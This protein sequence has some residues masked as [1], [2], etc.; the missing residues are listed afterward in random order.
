MESRRA[1]RGVMAIVFAASAAMTIAWCTSMSAMGGM[2]MPGGWA[3]SMMWMW[4]PKQSWLGAA[5]SFVGMWVVMMVAMM[6]PS[7]T[8]TLWRYRESIGEAG[9]AWPGWLTSLVGAAYFAVWAV[10]AVIVF[11]LGS[12]LAD[13]AMRESALAHVVPIVVGVAVLVAGVIQHTEW[14]ARRLAYC[15]EV[16]DRHLTPPVGAGAAWREGWCLGLHCVQSCAGLT[17]AMLAVG[18]MDLRTMAAVAAAVTFERV[19]PSGMRVARI[20]GVV[21]VAVGLVVIVQAAGVQ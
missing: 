5:A 8:P 13:I 16:A 7:L 19:A 4:S 12:A 9:G 15:R 2:E 6:L 21:I 14:K 1:F 17:L 20:I 11:A 3:M 18:V 10:L